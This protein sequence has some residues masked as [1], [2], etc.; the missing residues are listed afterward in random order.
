MRSPCLYI[1]VAGFA[2]LVRR[3]RVLGHFLGEDCAI[4]RVYEEFDGM[5]WEVKVSIGDSLLAFLEG[6]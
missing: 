5:G 2:G 4:L 1:S 6:I 3:R